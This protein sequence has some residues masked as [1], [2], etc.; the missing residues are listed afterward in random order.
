MPRPWPLTAAEHCWQPSRSHPDQ[1][2]GFNDRI[3]CC[4]SSHLITQ[5]RLR[6][7]WTMQ[8]AQT[9]WPL[10]VSGDQDNSPAYIS[11]R[12]KQSLAASSPG[13]N[14][15]LAPARWRGDCLCKQKPG[16]LQSPSGAVTDDTAGRRAEIMITPPHHWFHVNSTHT[17][18]HKQTHTHSTPA[19][20]RSTQLIPT[21]IIDSEFNLKVRRT[22]SQETL[23]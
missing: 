22:V 13:V 20:W 17:Y 23:L 16:H 1:A 9:T 6:G 5:E 3:C 4:S 14:V 12:T 15:C 2:N 18:T 19:C 8:R 10:S 11:L 21:L 7:P